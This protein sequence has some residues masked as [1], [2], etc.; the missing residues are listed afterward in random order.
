MDATAEKLVRAYIKMRDHRSQLKQQ[1]EEQDATV[2]EQ[3]DMVENHLLGLCKTT[4][5][6]SLRTKYGTV[7]RTVQTRYW[8]SDWE[9]MH[10]FITEHQALDLLERRISQRQMQEFI[11]ENPDVMPVG[12]NVDNRYTV[13]VR[14]SKS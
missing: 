7:S 6:D 11:K 5:A 1:Y 3:M 8:T 2:K 13:T 4:G 10:N 14:R 12:L 9:A